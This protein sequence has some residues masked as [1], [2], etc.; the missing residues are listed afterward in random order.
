MLHCVEYDYSL[1]TFEPC[2]QKSPAGQADQMQH[3]R[4]RFSHDQCLNRQE[5]NKR[6][7]NASMCKISSL[8]TGS[9]ICLYNF[10]RWSISRPNQLIW[11]GT[12]QW[13]SLET[14]NNGSISE[15]RIILKYKDSKTFERHV[16]D[17]TPRRY[18]EN[19]IIHNVLIRYTCMQYNTENDIIYLL[20]KGKHSAVLAWNSSQMP[21]ICW[22]K[23]VA[24]DINV[25]SMLPCVKFLD[26]KPRA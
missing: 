7:F 8:W 14:R 11:S 4:D 24:G 10:N 22:T 12:N 21:Q 5:S 18:I 19:G 1:P 13:S 15:A 16:L 26:Y 20:L 17:D 25:V 6:G 9:L 3:S 23:F 2:R